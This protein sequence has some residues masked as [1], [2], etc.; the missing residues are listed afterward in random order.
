MIDY[1]RA[2]FKNKD[3]VRHHISDCYGMNINRYTRFSKRDDDEIK[4]CT[5]FRDFFNLN[6]KITNKK[7]FVENSLHT[8]YNN[9]NG[10]EINRNDNDF[11]YNNL[12]SSLDYVKNLLDCPLEDAFLSQGLEF[13]FN[14]EVPFD[15]DCFIN[16][17]CVFYN[18]R[19]HTSTEDTD[20]KTIKVFSKGY[21]SFK[22]YNKGKQF[23][24]PYPLLRIELKFLDKR[25]FNNL[26][27]YTLSDLSDKDN[28][29]KIFNLMYSELDKHLMMVDNIEVREFTDYKKKILYR[30]CSFK[31][32]K[33][34]PSFKLKKEKSKCL[35]MLQKNKL[36]NNKIFVLDA[37]KS[38]FDELIKE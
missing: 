6:I 11:T 28:L 5:Y 36:L 15:V 10:S 13:G 27:I 29:Q 18:Y 22:I 3:T 8:L 25:G 16:N 34:L 24:L 2:Y 21:C 9:I 19:T 38:K 37:I 20:V 12:L 7:G 23:Q 14:I 17:D 33:E 4:Y 31:F 35:K 1:I 30:Y 32:W 26:G